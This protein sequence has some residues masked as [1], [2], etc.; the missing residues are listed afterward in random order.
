MKITVGCVFQ[1]LKLAITFTSIQKEKKSLEK[2][3]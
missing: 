3:L 1:K 2:D